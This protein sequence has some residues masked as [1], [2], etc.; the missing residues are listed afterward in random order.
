MFEVGVISFRTTAGPRP[1]IGTAA[2]A[3]APAIRR[4]VAGQDFL[5]FR[6]L[7]GCEDR[8]RVGD[9]LLEARPHFLV[10]RLLLI[11]VGLLNL[12]VLRLVVGPSS[13]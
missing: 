11:A 1:T 5:V 3:A 7:L 12:V 13:A 4:T 8:H 6:L 10:E 2:R 9:R